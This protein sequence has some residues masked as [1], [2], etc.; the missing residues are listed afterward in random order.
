M[1]EGVGT[2][3]KGRDKGIRD[4]KGKVGMDGVRCE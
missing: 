1:K 4:R 2:R 3:E